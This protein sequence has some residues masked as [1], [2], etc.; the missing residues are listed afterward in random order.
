MHADPLA[1][2][3]ARALTLAM[4]AFSVAAGALLLCLTIKGPAAAVADRYSDPVWQVKLARGLGWLNHSLIAGA[5]QKTMDI[6]VFDCKGLEGSTQFECRRTQLNSRLAQVEPSWQLTSQAPDDG[7]M[8]DVLLAMRWLIQYSETPPKLSALLQQGQ[9]AA[10]QSLADPFRLSGCI[11][12]SHADAPCDTKAAV[13]IANLPP[14]V[15]SLHNILTRYVSATRGNSPNIKVLKFAPSLETPIDQG[16]DVILSLAPNIQNPAQI[17]AA[18]YSGD[19]AACQNCKWCTIGTA[20]DMFEQARVRAVGILVLDAQTGGIEAAASA[21]TRCYVLQ[22]QGNPPAPDCPVLPNT[23]VRHLD[24]MEN[25]AIEQTAKPGSITKIV[26]AVGLQKAGLNSTEVAALPDILTHSRTADLIDIVMCKTQDFEPVC[27]KRRLT[28]IADAAVI[29]GWNHEVDILG[30]YQLPGLQAQRFTGRLLSHS[31]GS[32]MISN[33]TKVTFTRATLRDC[34]KKHWR[35]CQGEQLVN[36]VAELF[37]TGE[38]LASP[39]GVA[40]V[41]LQVAA[42]ANAQTLAPQAHLVQSAQDNTGKT[43]TVQ[44]VLTKAASLAQTDLVLQG[45]LK[46]ATQGTARSACLA[47]ASAMPG[48]LLPCV[49]PAGGGSQPALRIAGKTGTPVFSADQGDKKSLSL[50]QWRSQCEKIRVGMAAL[51]KQSQSRFS[52]SNEAG[53]CNMT[54]TKWYAFL[55]SAPASKTWDKVIVVLA[56]R[57][58]NQQTGLIDS[59]ND[60]GA[61]VAAEIGLAMVN[62]LYRPQTPGNH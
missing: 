53:K 51:H 40:N 59:P 37:G 17:T 52:L 61:N 26:I 7:N 56:E 6:K 25:Q 29:M 46:T 48:S 54:P 27:T 13:N 34:S 50:N 4:L 32:S 20:A 44:A 43:V 5:S 24:R 31:R 10:R 39:V 23:L 8:A 47:A 38:A 16:R 36:L 19:A 42:S 2:P 14:H 41:L 1:N 62:G 22:Q 35:N 60:N 58:W 33:A 45:L 11:E 15:T 49:A 21:Y 30:A 9:D 18:C 12:F 3:F 57:N 55:V 28:A